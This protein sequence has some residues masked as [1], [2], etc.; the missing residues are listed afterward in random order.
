MVY[1]LIAL[2]LFGALTLTLSSQNDQADSDDLSEEQATILANDLIEHA[3]SAQNVVNN[4][5]MM[6]SDIDDINFVNPTSDDFNDEDN[7]R[8][9]HKVFHPYGG[10]LNF[11]FDDYVDAYWEDA[12][13]RGW[14]HM[15]VTNVEWTPTTA[16]DIIYSFMDVDSAICE[17]INEI[18][19]GDSTIPAVTNADVNPLFREDSTSPAPE[20]FTVAKCGACEGFPTLCVSNST[21]ANYVFYNILAAR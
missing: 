9:I 19:T 18:I 11:K 6:G 1:V 16:T 14:R 4:M 21:A 17:E 8:H 15:T 20:N 13:R 7:I 5:L 12:T 10:G 3:A 2:A